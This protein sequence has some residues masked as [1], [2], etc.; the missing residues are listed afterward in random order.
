MQMATVRTRGGEFHL[1]SPLLEGG[2]LGGGVNPMA[3]I[4]G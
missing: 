2:P 4:R 1:W 3:V